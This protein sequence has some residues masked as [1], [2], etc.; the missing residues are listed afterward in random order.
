MGGYKNQVKKSFKKLQKTTKTKLFKNNNP[1]LNE[2]SEIIDTEVPEAKIIEFKINEKETD[3]LAYN[4]S[5]YNPFETIMNENEAI[6]E[7]EN[8]ND[9][10]EVET[11]ENDSEYKKEDFDNVFLKAFQDCLQTNFPSIYTEEVILDL[12]KNIR[13]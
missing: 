1:P 7:D 6:T 5:V 2:P 12:N 4:V 8:A 11:V 10:S 3:V 9:V 13:T